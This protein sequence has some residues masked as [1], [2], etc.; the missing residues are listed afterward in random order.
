MKLGMQ[1]VTVVYSSGDNGVAG[2]GGACLGPN[3][4]QPE[5]GTRFNPGFPSA[6][7]YITA[8][9]ATQ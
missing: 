6:C 3:N 1:G 8:V 5:D 9:G 2:N 4:T 7:P